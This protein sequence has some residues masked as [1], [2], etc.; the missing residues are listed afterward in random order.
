MHHK[1]ETEPH[2]P[3]TVSTACKPHSSRT[4]VKQ[5]AERLE[6]FSFSERVHPSLKSGCRLFQPGERSAV[7]NSQRVPQVVSM[8]Q[9]SGRP[10]AGVLPFVGGATRAKAPCWAHKAKRRQ[11]SQPVKPRW[12]IRDK[13]KN[14]ELWTDSHI[15]PLCAIF[16]QRRH[17]GPRAHLHRQRTMYWQ[18]RGSKRTCHI[19]FLGVCNDSTGCDRRPSRVHSRCSERPL[20]SCSNSRASLASWCCRGA[21]GVSS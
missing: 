1:N 20:R 10:T 14:P 19:S 8:K 9:A 11:R 5:Q 18:S 12:R 4:C 6:W 3:H 7:S 13:G 2:N 15:L 21:T 17:A 16:D